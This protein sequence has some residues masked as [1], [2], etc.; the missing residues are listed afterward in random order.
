MTECSV[1]LTNDRMRE[2]Q[3]VQ[4]PVRKAS[5]L[6]PWCYASQEWYAL[7]L[8]NIFF[9]EWLSVGLLEQIPNAGEYF[10]VD[11]VGEP[12]ILVRDRVGTVRALS[13]VCRH[14]GAPVVQGEG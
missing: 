1:W 13:A 12:I 3:L 11:V 2:L 8:E 10:T 4:Q 5:T 9:K 14:R 6:P 7:E